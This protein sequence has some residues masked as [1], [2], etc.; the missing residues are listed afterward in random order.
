MEEER[1]LDQ[2]IL[3]KTNYDYRTYWILLWRSWQDSKKIAA[4]SSYLAKLPLSSPRPNLVPHVYLSNNALTFV[5]AGLLRWDEADEVTLEGNPW[6]CGCELAWEGTGG[7]DGGNPSNISC[8]QDI[9]HFRRLSTYLILT[10]CWPVW[11]DW[12]LFYYT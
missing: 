5:S 8:W 11:P 7:M 4:Y 3:F 2:D 6:H 9:V 1:T 12:P 10:N